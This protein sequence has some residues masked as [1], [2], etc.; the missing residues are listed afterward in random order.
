LPTVQA[1]EPEWQGRFSLRIQSEPATLLSVGF[2]LR[3]EATEGSLDFYSPLGTTLAALR[4]SPKDVQLQQGGQVQRFDSMNELTEQATGAA[5]PISSLFDWLHGKPG[6][7]QGWNA[8]LGQ[9]A[10]GRISAQRSKPLPRADL[11]IVLDR[12][13]P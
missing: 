11:R 7:Q 8:D 12:P 3:G 10:Q 1:S 6:Q 2:R 9:L 5:L 13:A 4:W